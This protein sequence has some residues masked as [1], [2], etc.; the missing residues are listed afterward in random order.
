MLLLR[1]AHDSKRV[2]KMTT[3][4][5]FGTTGML[6]NAVL[7]RMTSVG[8]LLVVGTLRRSAE[9]GGD[10]QTA[11]AWRKLLVDAD[12]AKSVRGGQLC[13]PTNQQGSYLT[14]GVSCSDKPGH[15]LVTPTFNCLFAFDTHDYTFHGL[16]E[17]LRF[18]EGSERRSPILYY[19]TNAVRTTA[20]VAIQGPCSA[21]WKKARLY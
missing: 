16:P 11:A 13:I 1:H 6:G 8:R 5:I 4:L 19:Y 18:A 3:L 14:I 2:N 9:R 10:A 15:S 17:L 7:R 20:A 21:L 12:D